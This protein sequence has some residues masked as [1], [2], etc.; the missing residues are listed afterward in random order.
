MTLAAMRDAH[1]LGFRYATLQA[2]PMGYP[3]YRQLGF[4]EVCRMSH[5]AWHATAA[6]AA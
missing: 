1:A 4:R 3:V 2:S 5:W 6:D